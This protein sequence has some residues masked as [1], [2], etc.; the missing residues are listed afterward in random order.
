[1][2]EYFSLIY[3]DAVLR[4][5]LACAD[6]FFRLCYSFTMRNVYKIPWLL[7][8]AGATLAVADDAERQIKNETEISTT[9]EVEYAFPT[10]ACKAAIEIEYYQKGSSAHVESSLTNDEC[11]ASSGTYV[12]QIRY[13]G[14]DGQSQSKEF[15]ETWERLDSSPVVVEKDYFVADDVDILRVRSRKLNCTCAPDETVDGN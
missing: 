3:L 5:I 10:N 14:A 12:I 13:R 6:A 4:H 2:G 11:D 1:M 8:L 15:P 9:I 7:V